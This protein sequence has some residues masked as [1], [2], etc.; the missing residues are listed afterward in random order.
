MTDY[1][2]AIFTSILSAARALQDTVSAE[3]RPVIVA[4]GR[5]AGVMLNRELHGD[6]DIATA[7][8]EIDSAV[9][10]LRPGG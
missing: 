1:A 7:Q 3:H 10:R 4:I 8:E 6:A 9:M 2:D 5:A